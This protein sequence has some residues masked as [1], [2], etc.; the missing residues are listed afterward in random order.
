MMTCA[1]KP[2]AVRELDLLF[3]QHAETSAWQHAPSRLTRQ[4]GARRKTVVG[5]TEGAVERDIA[6]HANG[7]PLPRP[8]PRRRSCRHSSGQG[9]GPAG[10]L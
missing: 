7:C 2:R 9:G 3:M 4:C 8:P 6:S 10:D 1:R 5:D